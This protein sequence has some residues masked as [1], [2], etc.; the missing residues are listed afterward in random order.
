M[1]NKIEITLLLAM[2]FVY[3]YIGGTIITAI[4][5]AAPMITNGALSGDIVGDVFLLIMLIAASFGIVIST[6]IIIESV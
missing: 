6:C 1:K 3:S 4:L 2:I 5:H